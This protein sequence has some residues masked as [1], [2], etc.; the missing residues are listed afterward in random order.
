MR[1]NLVAQ[2]YAKAALDNVAV[3]KHRSFREDIICLKQVFAANKE[4]AIALNSYLYPFKERLQLAELVTEKLKLQKIWKSL[5]QILIKKHRF[6]ILSNV[7]DYLEHYLLAEEDK[8]KTQLKLAYKHDE[9]MITKIIKIVEKV[10][11]SKIEASVIIDPSIIGGFV[12]ETESM[13]IDG[14]I[15]NNLVKLV[16]TSSKRLEMRSE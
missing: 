2:R 6:N 16:Q 13:R 3:D 5:F 15:H 10:L 9:E 12:A 8:V 7:L 1:N 4:Y 14:S 11:H